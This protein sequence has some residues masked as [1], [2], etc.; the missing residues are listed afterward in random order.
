[1]GRLRLILRL[2]LRD[3][4]RRRTEA[5]LLFV[6]ITAATTTLALGLALHGVTAAPYQATRDATTGPDVV[7]KLY[8]PDGET[9]V[10]DADLARL[11]DL[12]TRP[13]V[14]AHSGPFPTT[15]GVLAGRGRVAG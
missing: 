1:M 2:A 4:R 12:A 10:R 15:W 7:A 6:A 8:A 11:A 14:V 3:L 5:A 13:E 9:A